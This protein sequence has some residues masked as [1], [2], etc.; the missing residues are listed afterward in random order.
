MSRPLHKHQAPQWKTF[1]RRFCTGPQTRGHSGVVIPKYF[2][3]TLSFVVL[4]KIRL[5]KINKYSPPEN[6]FC[7]PKL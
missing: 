4:R 2:L 7:S 6:V 5:H 3:F 1:W